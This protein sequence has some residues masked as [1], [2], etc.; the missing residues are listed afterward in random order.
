MRVCE[1]G[2]V[3]K[4]YERWLRTELGEKLDE[5]LT[6]RRHHVG[7]IADRESADGGDRQLTDLEHL[8]VQGDEKRTQ[9]LG[10]RQV[11]VES[12]VQARQHSL[13]DRRICACGMP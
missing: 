7:G 4:S 13:P 6:E 5:R 12:R 8:V 2:R 1:E 9:V 3:G 10:L 11:V